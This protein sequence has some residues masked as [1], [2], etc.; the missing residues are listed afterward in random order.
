MKHGPERRPSDVAS[1]QS[2]GPG[3]PQY[4]SR[5]WAFTLPRSRDMGGLSAS[6]L[7]SERKGL[8]GRSMSWMTSKEKDIET[9]PKTSDRPKD[10]DLRIPMPPPIQHPFTISHNQT[11]GW[12]TP[13][14]PRIT[15]NLSRPPSHPLLGD[16]EFGKLHTDDDHKHGST[17]QKRKRRF[18]AFILSNPYVPLV[19]RFYW[20]TP[21][22]LIFFQLF[23]VINIAFTTAAL[24]VAIRIRLYE[25]HRNVMGA[26]GSSPYVLTM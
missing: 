24:A 23:R 8:K 9:S 25:M 1:F 6:R 19:S 7:K 20:R 16:G 18:R 11:P 13:W 21:F 15:H 10:W 17:W 2:S 3:D 12:D 4:G 5:W 14:T 26:V 22:I